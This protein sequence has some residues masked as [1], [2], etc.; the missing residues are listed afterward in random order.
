METKS[1]GVVWPRLRQWRDCLLILLLISAGDLACR[2]AGRAFLFSP[3]AASGDISLSEELFWVAD[4]R[5]DVVLIG[6]S[7]TGTG[8]KPLSI[9]RVLKD[10][11]I[12]ANVVSIWLA[13]A[14]LVETRQIIDRGGAEVPPSARCSEHEREPPCVS[15]AAHRQPS[16]G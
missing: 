2:A 15:L 11:G 3:W 8:L 4:R 10:Q 1:P 13:G 14:G 5:P 7:R 6:D 9:E 12:D 16:L